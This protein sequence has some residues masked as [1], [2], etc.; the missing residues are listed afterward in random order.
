MSTTTE[1]VQRPPST[2]KPK[3]LNIRERRFIRGIAEGLIPREAARKAGYTEM[4]CRR[5]GSEKL[6]DPRFINKIA[7]I[8]E[9]H[10]V[11]D[12]KLVR[13]LDEGLDSTKVISANIIA[14]NGEGMSDAHGTTK[15]FVE[16]PDYAT[17]HKYLDT[18]LKLGNHYPTEQTGQQVN[19]LVG[20]Q[21]KIVG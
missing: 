8:M 15:D 4:T 9:R 16:V 2:K 20:L 21:V 14:Q 6:K 12:E 18:A 13:K 5:M 19:V 1:E 7:I 17:R 11:T 10:G 3:P